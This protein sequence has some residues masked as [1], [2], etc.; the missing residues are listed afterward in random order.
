MAI[1][2]TRSKHAVKERKGLKLGDLLIP[3]VSF[4][5]FVILFIF[6]YIPLMSDVQDMRKEIDTLQD[7]QRKLASNQTK[8][9]ELEDTNSQLQLDLVVAERIIPNELDVSDFAFYIDELAK[10]KNLRL[11]EIS[12]SDISFG[13]V[14]DKIFAT[15][16]VKGVSGPLRYRGSFDEI[17]EFLELVKRNAPYVIDTTDVQLRQLESVD[18]D[19]EKVWLVDLELTGYYMVEYDELVFNPLGNLN[20]YSVETKAMNT[21][22]N[23]S[24]RIV[25]E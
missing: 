15:G 20:L 9:R 22:V 14:E 6:V 21:L 8:I 19:G 18:G 23:K 1:G 13:S 10:E 3:M 7:K 17:V 11:E 5:L 25:E 2:L 16:I 24:N 4:I 12:S